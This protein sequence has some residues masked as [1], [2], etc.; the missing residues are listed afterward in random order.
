[1]HQNPKLECFSSRLAVI[2]VESFEVGCIVGNEDVVAAAPVGAAPTTSEW[3]TILLVTNVR[4]ILEVWQY[5][6]YR[7][8]AIVMAT[9][10]RFQTSP[11]MFT[12]HCFTLCPMHISAPTYEKNC[13]NL[14]SRRNALR[15]EVTKV[16]LVNF[17]I[18]KD[19]NFVHS[20]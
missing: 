11:G 15:V 8:E 1:M 18:R 2:F 19:F 20:L 16:S 7:V 17:S 3:S 4:L 13:S 14:A 6:T 12:Q 9:S 5:N 10:T